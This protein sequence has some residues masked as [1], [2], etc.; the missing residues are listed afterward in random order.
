[1]PFFKTNAIDIYNLQ[2][3]YKQKIYKKKSWFTTA[4]IIND[5]VDVINNTQVNS[6]KKCILLEQLLIFLTYNPKF[7]EDYLDIKKALYLKLVEIKCTPNKNQKI[8]ARIINHYLNLFIPKKLDWLQ[9]I[10]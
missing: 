3:N 1:M 10:V 6:Y 4:N 8:L 7:L 2:F 9:D 5:Y